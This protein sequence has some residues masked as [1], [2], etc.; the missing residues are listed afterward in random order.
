MDLNK[1]FYPKSIAVVGASTKPGSVGNDIVRNLAQQG[2]AGKVFP[3]NPKA[4]ELYG[5]PCYP[6]LS[7][8]GQSVDLMVIVVPAAIVPAILEEGGKLGIKG[9]IIISAGFKEV[10]QLELEKQIEAICLKNDITLIGP[11]CLGVINPEIKMNASFA[12]L[13]PSAGSVAFISQSGA[14]CTAVLDYAQKL[15]LGFSKFMSIGNKAIVDELEV[16]EY[17]SKDEKTR[18]IALYAEQL[19]KSQELIAMIK[20]ITREPEAK[21]VIVLKSGRTSAGASASASHTGALAGNDSAY[22]ALFRQSGAIRA[23]SVSE[24]FDYIQIFVDNPF[25]PAKNVAV[26]TNAGGPGVLAADEIITSGLNLAS[27]SDKTTTALKQ[28]LPACSN[29]HNPIDIL[30]DAPA[31]RYAQAL[32]IA[33]ADPNID[34]LLVILTPQS[35]TE[36]EATAQAI[37]NIK[38]KCR[39]PI[40]VSFMGEETVRSGVEIMRNGSVANFLFPE[41]ASRSLSIMER[42]QTGTK[43]IKEKEFAF[44]D[45]DKTG[46]RA[47]FDKAK[48]AGQHSF[49]ESQALEILSLYNFPVLNSCLVHNV[50]EAVAAATK[51]NGRIALKI[52]SPDILHKNDVGGVTL[53]VEPAD[54]AKKYEEMMSRVAK[55]KPGAKLEGA[56]IVEMIPHGAEVILGSSRD[57]NLGNMIMVGLGG[58]YVE[59]L[60]DVV[61]GLSPLTAFD[62]RQM[63]DS[64]K[65]KKIFAGVRGQEPSDVE[66]LVDCLGRLSQLLTDFPEIKELDINP[67]RLL[68]SGQGA[69]VLDARIVID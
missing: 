27:L 21:P 47:I 28:V 3:V 67:L 53:D 40:A 39:K 55:N 68:A 56:L 36:I 6:N 22:E 5:L 10:G 64:I 48:Q 52:V 49:P 61:F 13:M 34:S 25:N 51:I 4:T 37:K 17:L 2:F 66:A 43:K 69:R 65:A 54:V 8:I 24:F 63:I 11:N 12:A 50:T 31:D 46:V 14:L 9:A 18:V 26:I 7:A 44:T 45:I 20:K 1:V 35:M 58:I 41:Q 15:N 62:A 42:F 29:F 23:Y 59:I 60:K 32:E 30:G 33:A 16:L 38:D 19:E 57:A